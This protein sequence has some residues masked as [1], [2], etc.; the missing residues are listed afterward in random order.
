MRCNR[1]CENTLD[2]YNPPVSGI[3]E[4]MTDLTRSK[5]ENSVQHAEMSVIRKKKD[6][7]TLLQLRAWFAI[8]NPFDVSRPELR[9]LSTSL[10]AIEDDN[11]NCDDAESIGQAMQ[12]TLD[13]AQFF[14]CMITVRILSYLQD[15]VKIG[16]DTV[17]I[18]PEVLSID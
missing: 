4:A 18:M 17:H 2:K 14:N 10:V 5:H 15:F 1:V 3:H 6:N 8:N 11:I 12:T 16:N 7:E 13:G 9:S